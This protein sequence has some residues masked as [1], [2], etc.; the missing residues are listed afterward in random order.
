MKKFYVVFTLAL[1]LFASAFVCKSAFAEVKPWNVC[2]E[3]VYDGDVFRYDLADKADESSD[4]SQQRGFYLGSRKKRE[5]CD[6]LLA[7]GLPERAVYNYIL[8]DFDDVLQH[9][10]YVRRTRKDAETE[11][12]KNGF[13]YRK[14]QDGVE[15]NARKLFDEM[16]RSDGK[17]IKIDLPLIVDE[18]LSAEQLKRNTVLRGSFGTSFRSSG[19]NRAHNIALAASSLDG[20]TVGAGES[21]SFN[22][23][24][25]D[26][27]VANGYKTSKVILDGNYAEGVG[28]GVCQ[29][30]TTL[31]NAL[32]LA[33]F[34]P[35]AVQ[36]SLVS[37]YV[38]AG[39]DAMVSYGAAD[40]TFVN[41]TD[42]PVYIAAKVRDKTITFS[43]YGEPNPYKIVRENV[44]IRD[45]FAT[46][47]VT[48]RQKYPD[49]VYTDQMKVLVS[50]SDGVKTKSYL[51]YYLNGKL[52]DTKLIR[53]NSYKRVDAVVARGGLQ[54]EQSGEE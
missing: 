7:E 15:I 29:V 34:V 10:D 42:H 38:M 5:F 54:R 36:H 46:T 28:G 4:R 43:V 44:E 47:Y 25:G 18:A 6:A 37:S 35:K 50:G 45:K 53:V 20:V 14:S 31:Y 13:S 9:F 48:D 8:P 41:D 30:S 17:P 1:A 22:E 51:K 52:T 33:G 19:A 32:L 16:L 26:R 21:F 40:L 24:V 39:F 12:G 2:A 23:T 3:V 27:T 11:F 49:L